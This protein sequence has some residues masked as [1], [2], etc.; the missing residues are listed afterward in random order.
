MKRPVR[1]MKKEIKNNYG[2][3]LNLVKQFRFEQVLNTK[4]PSRNMFPKKKG[5]VF[6]EHNWSLTNSLP[7]FLCR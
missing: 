1:A 4:R 2:Y 7:S 3:F 5:A 6:C